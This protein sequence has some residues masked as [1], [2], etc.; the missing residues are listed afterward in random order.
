MSRRVAHQI[1][2]PGQHPR[3][4]PNVTHLHA[5]MVMQQRISFLNMRYVQ[6]THVKTPL[7]LKRAV[8][9]WQNALRSLAPKA[10]F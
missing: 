9:L 6:G 3:S 1:L 7:I 4:L 5:L 2:M 10:T 8:S